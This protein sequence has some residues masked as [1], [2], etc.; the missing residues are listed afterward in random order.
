M[1]SYRAI[2]KHRKTDSAAPACHTVRLSHSL[3]TSTRHSN[4]PISKDIQQTALEANTGPQRTDIS[5]QPQGMTYQ[6]T[7]VYNECPVLSIKF[8]DLSPLTT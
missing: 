5:K 1:R 7:V 4:G 2:A 3:A 6:Y 8:A